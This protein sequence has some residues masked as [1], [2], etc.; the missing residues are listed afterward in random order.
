M[1]PHDAANHDLLFGRLALWTG[2]TSQAQLIGDFHA[3]TQAKHLPVT[4][5]LMEQD[6]LD[7]PRRLRIEGRRPRCGARTSP[8]RDVS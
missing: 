6:V 5:I 3:S 2:L 8:A 4:D 1:N 7:V